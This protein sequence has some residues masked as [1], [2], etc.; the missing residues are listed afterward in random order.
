MAKPVIF[1]EHTACWAKEVIGFLPEPSSSEWGAEDIMCLRSLLPSWE[2]H[3]IGKI[4]A[5]VVDSTMTSEFI[6]EQLVSFLLQ[7]D[8]E[9][10][11]RLIS[12]DDYASY[13]GLIGATLCIVLSGQNSQNKWAKLWAL[14]SK[15]CLIEFQ[16]ELQ[17]DGSC[18]H[19]AHVAEYHSWI[20]LLSK[21]NKKDVQ[22]QIMEQMEKWY[23]KNSFYLY[24]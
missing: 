6:N 7:K 4:C 8:E 9:W 1:D 24:T 16:Q 15:C 22:A 11:I 13:D 18:T 14:P 19:L 2:K 20:L 3:P 17:L 21:G 23:K 12:S 10:T 5:V